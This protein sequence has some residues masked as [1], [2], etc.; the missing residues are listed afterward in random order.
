M[1]RYA[2]NLHLL[3]Y[4]YHD[5][6]YALPSFHIREMWVVGVLSGSLYSLGNFCSIIAV[7][8]LGQGVGYSFTQT[9]MLISGLWGIFY[10]K[11]VKGIGRISKW[12]MSS[13][14]TIVGI[15]WLSYEHVGAPSGH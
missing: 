4:N 10:F 6:Y 5:A 1:I 2:Y 13:I 9:S 7:T 3:E 15:L 8:A 14:I 12:I 11:E